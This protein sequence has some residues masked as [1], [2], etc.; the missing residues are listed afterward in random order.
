MH[1][2]HWGKKLQNN[3]RKLQMAN[4]PLFIESID[5][6]FFLSNRITFKPSV[7]HRSSCVVDW[8]YYVS[9]FL[10]TSCFFFYNLFKSPLKQKKSLVCGGGRSKYLEPFLPLNQT[11][12]YLV[13]L[14]PV[15]IIVF[16]IRTWPHTLVICEQ[17]HCIVDFNTITQRY[18]GILLLSL[19]I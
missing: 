8:G 12:I 13:Q 19:N 3:Q 5:F 15:C 16:L 11:C 1:L 6:Y 10:K 4:Q 2:N 7:F 14:S 17:C 18:E 9:S